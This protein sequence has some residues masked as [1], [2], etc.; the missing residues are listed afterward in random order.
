[1]KARTY[2]LI[3]FDD[4][5]AGPER[6]FVDL[7]SASLDARKRNKSHIAPDMIVGYSSTGLSRNHLST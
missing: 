4:Q 7:L 5:N 2:I 1:M 6:Q 3:L